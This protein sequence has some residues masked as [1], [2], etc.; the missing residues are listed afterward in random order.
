MQEEERGREGAR[1]ESVFLVGSSW[2]E[3]DPVPRTENWFVRHQI[4]KITVQFYMPGLARMVSDG[5]IGYRRMTFLQIL[6]FPWISDTPRGRR[7]RE[8]SGSHRVVLRKNDR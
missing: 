3:E 5:P 8:V 6:S 4:A 1:R 2:Q 7:Q